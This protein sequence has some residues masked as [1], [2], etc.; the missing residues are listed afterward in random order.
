M[1]KTVKAIIVCLLTLSSLAHAEALKSKS[2]NFRLYGLAEQYEWK[3]Y[4]DG[5]RVLKESGPL[6]GLGG[7]LWLRIAEPIWIEGR[8]ELFI[9][10]V[11]YDG[12]IMTTDGDLIPYKS[13][14]EYA[15]LKV[16][17]DIAIKMPIGSKVN[18]K[19]YAGFGCRAWRRTLDT[20]I[21]DDYIGEYGYEEDWVTVYG[22]IGCRGEISVSQ[23]GELFARIEARL[24]INNSMKAD[25]SNIDGP[26]NVELEPGKRPSL[27][28][29]AG[30]N[31]TPITVSFFVETLE[32]S[33]SPM[34]DKYQAIFQPESKSTMVG[35][36]FGIGF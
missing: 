3:E 10:D 23:N 34:D 33:E 35:A 8:G 20:A 32:F 6:F 21:G 5:Q 26:S 1:K 7:E 15:G 2:F 12:A 16:D 36:K 14:T 19:P 25:L 9:G 13:T 17:G 24:P 28:A 27:Y 18:F 31:M 11:D 29:D 22:I 30:L 4:L